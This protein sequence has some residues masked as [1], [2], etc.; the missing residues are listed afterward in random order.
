MDVRKGSGKETGMGTSRRK[1]KER[2]E[3]FLFTIPS[4]ILVVMM[5]YIPFVMSGFYSLTQC[6]CTVKKQATENNR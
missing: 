5:M 2:R 3:N 4:V 6:S 1:R